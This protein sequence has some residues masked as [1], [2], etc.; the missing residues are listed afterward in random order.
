MHALRREPVGAGREGQPGSGEGLR[1]DAGQ[2][3][4]QVGGRTAFR[5]VEELGSRAPAT[6]LIVGERFDPGHPG[7]SV[8]S[9][10]DRARP[11]PSRDE[12]SLAGLTVRTLAPVVERMALHRFRDE[13]GGELL[14]LP[15]APRPDPDTPAPV[16]FLPTWEAML[17]VHARRTEVLPESYRPLVFNT[18]TPHS[19]S[20]FL[21]DGMVPGTW[22]HEGG[23]IRW[24]S[25]EPLLRVARRKLEDEAKRLAAFH[26]E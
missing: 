23:C 12:A 19:M 20:T 5:S 6:D 14:D 9:A 15:R 7:R 1:L 16:R 22:R 3:P 18:R 4:D 11:D 8:G 21:V 13:R 10:G 2:L 26:A 24:E 25:F 17:L